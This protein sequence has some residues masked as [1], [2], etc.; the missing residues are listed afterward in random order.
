M[1]QILTEE[2]MRNKVRDGQVVS[3]NNN[4]DRKYRGVFFGKNFHLYCHVDV[5][6]GYRGTLY[7]ESGWVLSFSETEEFSNNM[8]PEFVADVR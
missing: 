6:R 4:S 2:Q 7:K 1:V 8:V 5:G 3:E